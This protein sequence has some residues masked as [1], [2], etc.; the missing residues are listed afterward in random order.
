[1]VQQATA[2][3]SVIATHLPT[4]KEAT[5][6][7]TTD[8]FPEQSSKETTAHTNTS[9]TTEAKTK[10]K[11]LI[12]NME[13]LQHK[14]DSSTRLRKIS[15]ENGEILTKATKLQN[16]DVIVI[17]QE[18][19]NQNRASSV[20]HAYILIIKD[21]KYK[22][23][24][25]ID[26]YEAIVDVLEMDNPNIGRLSEREYDDIRQRKSEWDAK[27]HQRN[28]PP[29]ETT[30]RTRFKGRDEDN[31]S[32]IKHLLASHHINKRLSS[33]WSLNHAITN[34]HA[35]RLNNVTP[36]EIIRGFSAEQERLKKLIPEGKP[37]PYGLYN[38]GNLIYG[39]VKHT[40]EAKKSEHKE[41]Y[42]S[43]L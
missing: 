18:Q 34:G 39:A 10:P 26:A 23:D 29:S 40:I 17:A 1:M 43:K 11:K 33:E 3:L 15:A 32:V 30:F 42:P 16:G 12:E 4:E 28:F 20:S 35:Y 5:T 24:G 37:Y 21:I 2:R 7:S 19:F 25:S 6:A 13:E 22:E 9:P 8:Y 36:D 14:L 38:C 27:L 31:Q 41:K